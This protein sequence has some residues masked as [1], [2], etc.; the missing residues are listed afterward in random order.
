MPITKAMTL[1]QPWAWLVIRGIKNI[2]NRGRR[3]HY[4]GRIAVH[5]SKTLRNEEYEAA[6][7]KY[8][9]PIPKK[10]LKLGRTIG[11]V[12]IADLVGS[13]R[14]KWFSRPYGLALAKP[15]PCKFVH[16]SGQFGLW[17]LPAR[18]RS[19]I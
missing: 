2:E 14:S 15:R 17:N 11:T 9:R 8:G 6:C 4:R 12:E 16:L 7:K 13:H 10:K 1:R 5:A 3:F 18:V 19:K